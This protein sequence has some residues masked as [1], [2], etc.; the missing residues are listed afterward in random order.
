MDRD[1][2]KEGLKDI[3]KITCPG[4]D[5]HDLDEK[6]WHYVR[7][8]QIEGNPP[9][10]TLHCHGCNRTYKPSEFIIHYES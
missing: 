6:R 4:E 2:N 8:E 3:L 10:V 1:E 7:K 9:K 5:T